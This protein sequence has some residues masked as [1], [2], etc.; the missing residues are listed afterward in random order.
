MSELTL[1][2]VGGSHDRTLMTAIAFPHSRGAL[3][4]IRP[5]DLPKRAAAEGYFTQMA[6][7]A[8]VMAVK[9]ADPY[10]L[11]RLETFHYVTA[12]GDEL[13]W[14]FWVHDGLSNDEAWAKIMGSYAR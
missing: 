13:Q 6:R 10:E 12:S 8:L 7:G 2:A 14:Q 3:T 5:L 4:K 11:Y 9:D 1:P